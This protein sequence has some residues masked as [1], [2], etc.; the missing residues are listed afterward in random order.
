[1][2]RA[3]LIVLALLASACSNPTPTA[4]PNAFDR[5]ED[6]AFFCWNLVTSSPTALADCR[7]PD[8]EIADDDTGEPNTERCANPPCYALHALVTQ[9]TTGEVAAVRLTGTNGEPGVIDTDVRIP[10]YTFAA[11]GEVPSALAISRTDPQNV[12]VLSRGSGDIQVIQTAQFRTGTGAYS[13]DFDVLRE[14]AGERVLPSAMQMV[15]GGGSLLVALPQAGQLVRL[16]VTGGSLGAPERLDLAG[17]MP[18][19][20][21]LTT[22]PAAARWLYTCNAPELFDPVPIAPRAPITLGAVPAPSAI[23]YDEENG[24]ILVADRAL[25]LIHRIDPTTFTEIGAVNVSVPLEAI[26]LTPK[27]PSTIEATEPDVRYLYAID[28]TDQS[29]LAVDWTDPASPTFGGVLSVEIEPPY[30][31]LNVPFRAQALAVVTPSYAPTTPLDTCT[32]AQNGT[33]AS[34]LNL[35][36]VFLTVGTSDGRV[37][38]FDVYDEDI[39]CRGYDD[40]CHTDPAVGSGR[41]RN[42]EDQ[43]V[44]I[45]RHRPRF[46][47]YMDAAIALDPEPTWETDSVGVELVAA[48]GTTAAP[49]LVPTLT[50]VTCEAP[51]DAIYPTDGTPLVCAVLDPWAAISQSFS[52]IFEG[53]IPFTSTSGGNFDVQGETT[54]LL[55]HVDY[56]RAGVLGSGDVTPGE[57]LGDYEGDV[58]AITGD[59]PPSILNGT[60]DALLSDCTQLVE[61]TTGG[62]ITP[63]LIQIVGAES[64]P[65]GV[66][67]TYDGRLELGTVLRPTDADL[68]QVLRCYPELLE[69]EVRTRNSFVVSAG[70]AGFRH[71]VEENEVTHRCQVNAD[72]AAAFER[73]RAHFGEVFRTPEL[74][75]ALGARPADIDQR[76]P[77]LRIAVAN[78][79]AGLNIDVSTV[80]GTS[81]PSLLTRL[82]YND[83]DQRL[84][85]VDQSV[86]GLLRIKLSRLSVQTTF[87]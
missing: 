32:D 55:S 49:E 45:G 4:N 71:P 18:D 24:E 33:F 7:P 31:R 76:H 79:P 30:D 58:L 81:G 19:P 48:D 44:A 14:A 47:S 36:G 34:G 61:R 78:V 3:S 39:A 80:G 75:F 25:P 35:H 16:P 42:V 53:A 66:H 15:P 62:E 73:G 38:F 41:D 26:V 51:L 60:D 27:V 1:M 40:S 82:V 56:C 69:V 68:S 50:P 59:L 72:R 21:D 13:T 8:F 23:L 20:V 54:Y 28:A 70:R 22:Q 65:A 2:K 83:V 17:T 64:H 6:V 85:A 12:F 74:T 84:Y 43:I 9:T 86:Q 87:R 67:E 37:R 10:G 5:P 63:V 46:G 11:V 57:Y 29:V 77:E 52:A